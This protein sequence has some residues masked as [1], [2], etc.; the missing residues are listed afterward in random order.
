MMNKIIIFYYINN[1]D[2]LVSGYF[3]ILEPISDKKVTNFN[4]ETKNIVTNLIDTLTSTQFGVG[5]S[6]IQVGIP[7]QIC[8]LKYNG[9]II[10]MINP[11]ITRMRGEQIIKEGCLSAP[12]YTTDVKR[13]QKVW[14]QYYTEDGILTQIADGGLCSAII[15]H[16]LDHFN[17]WCEV[18][19]ETKEEQE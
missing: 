17:G 13:A 6:A 19:N 14:C 8:V 1:L 15:Q 18:F 7:L 5:I 16:E 3:G 10:P 2:E 9:K 12:G 4:E 11:T